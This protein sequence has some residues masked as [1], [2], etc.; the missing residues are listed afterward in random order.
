MKRALSVLVGAA[1][2]VASLLVSRH[3]PASWQWGLLPWLYL[4]AGLIAW[5]RQPK[6]RTGVLLILTGVA[7]SMFVFEG[8]QIPLVWTIGVAFELA[9]LP[10][11]VALLLAF[12]TGR[13]TR[14]ERRAVLVAGIAMV[15]WTTIPAFRTDPT[16]L[17]CGTC[18]PDL[19]LL[20]AGPDEVA[21][22]KQLYGQF[23]NKVYFLVPMLVGLAVVCVVRW[24]RAS[25]PMR[26]I[27][28]P[29]L[30]TAVPLL[31]ALSA[32]AVGNYLGFYATHPEISAGVRDVST[33]AGLL[34]PIAILV[35]LSLGWARQA[36][37]GE[38]VTELGDHSELD[39]VERTMARVLG[40]PGLV[41]GRW[42]PE[43]QRYLAANGA[44][45]AAGSGQTTTYFEQNDAPMIAVVHDSALLDDGDLLSSAGAA[46][47]MAVDNGR[48][49]A[50]LNAQLAEVRASRARI[51]VAADN[52]RR[53]LERDLH[54]GAQ[55]R[56]V[57]LALDARV[58]AAK[59]EIDGDQA[60]ARSV[61]AIADG[62]TT[63]LDELRELARGIHP[64]V[65]V[66]EGLD[67]ALRS[68]TERSAVPVRL[69]AV[70]AERLEPA[71]EAVA[72]FV[73]SEALANA[74]KH[75]SATDVSI[76]VR[77]TT[78]RLI[79]EIRDNGKGGADPEGSGLRG[80]A[81]RVAAVD[82]RLLVN[83]PP[84]RGTCVRAEIPCVS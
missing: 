84:G 23:P 39:L 33:N 2:G 51:V 63:A 44:A 65:L 43:S 52:E 59:L 81:D 13:L 60:T 40:D 26:R 47:R 45:L 11:L 35:G 24:L 21:L 32:Q 56:L 12:P 41:L 69:V 82:G 61:A 48:L 9:F 71:V 15:C 17:G 62:L 79:V 66:D 20:Y 36:R 53:R 58:T 28:A 22:L 18:R 46:V 34:H 16:D 25:R 77:R 50:E 57:S 5:N 70:P 67:S 29:V 55:Q 10:A 75:A 54:D 4:V 27:S 31:L 72:Y 49:R 6:N 64:S 7:Y 78:G 76:A 3:D 38:I 83:S 68:L 73:V 8:S 19:N 1:A 42:D 30:V 80:L 14:W 37:I 74:A